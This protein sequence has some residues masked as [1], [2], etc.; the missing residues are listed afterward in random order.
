[1]RKAVVRVSA[2]RLS[3]PE[4]RER[5]R[6][7]VLDAAERTFSEK[8]YHAASLDEIAEDAGY[9]KGA[10]YSNFSG[11]ADL[12]L[13]VMDRRAEREAGGLAGQSPGAG[14]QGTPPTVEPSG[15]ALATLDF[16]LV[17]VHDERLRGLLAERYRQARARTSNLLPRQGGPAAGEPAWASPDEIATAAMA[18]GSGLIIQASL[19]DSAVAADLY[20]RIM[21]KLLS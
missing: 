12:F 13:A 10:V 6:E 9:S 8:G 4:L 11:K 1:L 15:W 5:T 2:R 21:S 16:F 14:A 17:A 18:V 20:G 19:D 3:R 7:R